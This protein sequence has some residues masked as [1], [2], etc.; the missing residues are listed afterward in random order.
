MEEFYLVSAPFGGQSN[1]SI[2]AELSEKT[3]S[4]V[5]SAAC[6]PAQNSVNQKALQDLQTN[7][8]LLNAIAAAALQ[9]NDQTISGAGVEGEINKYNAQNVSVQYYQCLP[10]GQTLINKYNNEY[11]PAY[12]RASQNNIAASNQ[13]FS[14]ADR[15]IANLQDGLSAVRRA[16]NAFETE[17]M[18]GGGLAAI[19][20]EIAKNSSILLDLKK[21]YF[22]KWYDQH[23]ARAAQYR[24]KIATLS[25]EV[26][27]SSIIDEL[28]RLRNEYIVAPKGPRPV[29]PRSAFS[30]GKGSPNFSFAAM[31]TG[32]YSWAIISDRLLAALEG[33]RADIGNKSLILTSG[34]RNPV[35]N[36]SEP[37][38]VPDSRHQ[39]GDA[40]D[41][42]PTDLN[43]DGAIS[44][45][46]QV[47]LASSARKFFDPK[48]VIEKKRITVH[49]EF[50]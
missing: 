36:D 34:Y 11:V 47:I 13:L 39:Y 15:V 31:N 2:V 50:D 17:Q 9:V 42:T 6:T 30:Q 22:G 26:T 8:D 7:I 35:A 49:M 45:A 25:N 23:D 20:G 40:A 33:I 10:S 43:G 14:N 44:K 5:V 4:V 21:F 27:Q 16:R 1:I 24:Q 41:V 46:D 37:D 38:S 12:N 18:G 28:D 19:E 48:N 3:K 32:D 29:P